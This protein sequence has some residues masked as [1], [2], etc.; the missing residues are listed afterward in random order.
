M[1]KLLKNKIKL[2]GLSAIMGISAC[3]V[4]AGQLEYEQYQYIAS[5]ITAISQQIDK[6]KDTKESH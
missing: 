5:Q 3:S 6:I 2:I 1:N 4:W